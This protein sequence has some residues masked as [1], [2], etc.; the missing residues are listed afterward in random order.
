MEITL[1][2]ANKLMKAINE[3]LRDSNPVMCRSFGQSS[4][5]SISISIS[6]TKTC[7]FF[8]S[9]LEKKK[10]EYDKKFNTY[11]SLMHDKYVL[12]KELFKKNGECGLSEVLSSLDFLNSKLTFYKSILEGIDGNSNLSLSEDI[13][14]VFNNERKA[15]LGT[16][17]KI[18]NMGFAINMHE[19]SGIETEIKNLKR[20]I[21]ELEDKKMALNS[22]KKIDIEISE[23]AKDL[24]G[25]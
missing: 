9:E 17:D 8:I 13:K 19:S 21:N 1:N 22:G 20:E 14:E 23:F 2:K 15:I 3:G 5:G 4:N 18:Q 25:L 16:E 11:Y 24:L 10:K 12:K 7:E 6:S